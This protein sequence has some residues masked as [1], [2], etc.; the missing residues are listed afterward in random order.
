MSSDDLLLQL[1]CILGRTGVKKGKLLS[2]FLSVLELPILEV[3]Q[4]PQLGS[5]RESN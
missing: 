2:F 3:C 4:G 1:S 5:D